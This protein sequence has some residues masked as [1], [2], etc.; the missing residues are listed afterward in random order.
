MGCGAST[1]SNQ[2]VS[3]PGHAPPSPP[4][5]EDDKKDGKKNPKDP[6]DQKKRRRE[7]AR[8]FKSSFW[9]NSGL[10]VKVIY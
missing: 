3:A 2:S 8:T 6:K 9:A 4:S 1:T 10:E 7:R 5:S